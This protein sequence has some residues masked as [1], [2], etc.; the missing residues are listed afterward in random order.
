MMFEV[1]RDAVSVQNVE[2]YAFNCVSAFNLFFVLWEA[3][4]KPIK[5]EGPL[6]DPPPITEFMP[7]GVINFIVS[8]IFKERDG[9]I[10]NTCRLIDG[11]YIDLL[12]RAEI[13]G[14]ASRNGLLD[15]HYR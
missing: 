3:M 2:T 11:A 7:E 12:S 14:V 6:K 4:G 13:S 8:S 10:H 1:V 9:D 5:V 15:Q